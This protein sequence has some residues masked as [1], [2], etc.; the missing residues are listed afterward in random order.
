[1]FDDGLEMH[2]RHYQVVL[3][4]LVKVID[5]CIIAIQHFGVELLLQW[6]GNDGQPSGDPVCGVLLIGL[7]LAFK[8]QGIIYGPVE[9]RIILE[10]FDHHL[11]AILIHKIIHLQNLRGLFLV[12]GGVGIEA[13]EF[14]LDHH[15]QPQLCRHHRRDIVIYRRDNLLGTVY[16]S[17]FLYRPIDIGRWL[18]VITYPLRVICKFGSGM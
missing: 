5:K 4:C 11:V 14:P 3:I 16:P 13:T 8:I 6:C 10:V 2:R 12:A 9:F 1:M 17:P 18:Y 7:A 15:K